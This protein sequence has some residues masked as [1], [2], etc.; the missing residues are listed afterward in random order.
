MIKIDFVDKF[1][2]LED[3]VDDAN[4]CGQLPT[5]KVVGFLATIIVTND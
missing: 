3:V 4:D 2:F 5:T 1:A